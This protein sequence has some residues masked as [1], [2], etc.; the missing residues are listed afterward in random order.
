LRTAALLVAL[1]TIVV[2]IVGIASPDLL[3]AVRRE[4]FAAPLGLYGAGAL[5]VAMALVVI[6]S[7]PASRAPKTLRVLGAAMCLQALVATL[8]GPERAREIL[9]WEAQQGAAVLRLGAAGA[10]AAGCFLA[11]AVSG[12][13]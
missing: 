9:E 11:F 3:T 6:L 4:Y 13:R 2:G 8:A 12:R 7:A 1:A 10:L 5:R